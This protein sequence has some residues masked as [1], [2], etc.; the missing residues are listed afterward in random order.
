MIKFVDGKYEIN[1]SV[2]GFDRDPLT[3]LI[4]EGKKSEFVN[5]EQANK[6]FNFS[7]KNYNRYSYSLLRDTEFVSKLDEMGITYQYQ[8]VE[9]DD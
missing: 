9:I 5:K 6:I 1:F 7:R 4:V 3:S 8:E 2:T